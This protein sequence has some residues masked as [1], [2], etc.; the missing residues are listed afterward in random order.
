MP[1]AIIGP[2]LADLSAPFL[3]TKNPDDGHCGL[4]S[5][6]AVV[7]KRFQANNSNFLS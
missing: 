7:V 5:I 4:F 1:L 2:F 6:R 3:V